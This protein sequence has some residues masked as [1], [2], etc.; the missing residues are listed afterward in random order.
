MTDNPHRDNVIEAHS[1]G[2]S[3]IV[4][5]LSRDGQHALPM[6]HVTDTYDSNWLLHL[7]G[8]E[9]VRIFL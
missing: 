1:S 3:Q 6:L 4:F 7:T 5:T 8:A 2:N 9:L